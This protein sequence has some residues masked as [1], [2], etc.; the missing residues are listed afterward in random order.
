MMR[1]RLVRVAFVVAVMSAVF[2]GSAVARNP[3]PPGFPLVPD[4]QATVKDEC[5]GANVAGFVATLEDPT[6]GAQVAPSKLMS[7][8]FVFATLS[9]P[10]YV[11]HLSAPGY[12][13]LGDPASPNPGVPISKNPGP[14]GRVTKDPGP[15]GL[16]GGDKVF[17]GL[18]LSI[19]LMP[20]TGCAAP[21]S[22]RPLGVSGK[23]LDLGTGLPLPSAM[24][25]LQPEPETPTAR[26]PGPIGVTNGVFKVS[27]LACGDYTMTLDAAGYVPVSPENAFVV[28]HENTAVCDG[29]LVS[30]KIAYGT[31]ILALIAS[32]FFDHAPVIDVMPLP[33]GMHVNIGAVLSALVHDPDIGDTLTYQW[34][35]T[36]GV[37]CVFS[38]PNALTTAITCTKKGNVTITFTVTDSFLKTD[39]QSVTVLV[40]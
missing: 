20:D 12:Q 29:P 2:A 4:V 17:E 16:P 15:P 24:V 7:S 3:G 28:Q 38:D 1:R 37:P 34:A 27:T 9:A 8:G 11:L 26:D 40:I 32:V 25:G 10:D 36:A 30:G 33:L 22:P 21:R 14:Q 23:V 39:S 13:S 6:T 19:M 35:D 5:T 18:R 31:N